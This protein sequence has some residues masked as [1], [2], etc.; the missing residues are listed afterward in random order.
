MFS[1][2]GLRVNRDLLTRL[3]ALRCCG[4]AD[5]GAT[6]GAHIPRSAVPCLVPLGPPDYPGQLRVATETQL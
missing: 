1:L 2:F 4:G 6:I 3:N 5:G